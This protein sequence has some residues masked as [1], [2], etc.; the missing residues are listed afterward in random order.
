MIWC[1][2]PNEK[3]NN[4]QEP[5]LKDK[6]LQQTLQAGNGHHDAST[7]VAAEQPAKK[8]CG[9]CCGGHEKKEA[10]NHSHEHSHDHVL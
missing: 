3:L 5:L 4:I 8:G 10:H 1:N 7:K 2:Y 9:G 6:V